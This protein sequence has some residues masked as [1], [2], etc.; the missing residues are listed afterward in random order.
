[1]LAFANAKINLGLFITEKR[2]DG[3]HNLDTVFYPIKINDVIEITDAAFTHCCIV[4]IDVPGNPD[5]NLCMEAYKAVSKDFNIPAQ[6]ITLLKNIPV[7][8]GLGGGSADAAFLIKLLNDK[9]K[10]G[11]T[12]TEME[13]YV[14][15][16]GADCAFFINNKPVLAKGKGDEFSQLELDLSAYYLVLVKPDIHVSTSDAYSGIKPSFPSTS[17]EELIHLPLSE[18]R[19]HVFNDFESSVF[20]IYPQIR[21]IKEA[22]YHEGAIFALMSGSGSSVFAIFENPVKLP[23][24]EK[25]NVVFYNV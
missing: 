15:P 2:T 4:G 6:Q 13:N 14:K 12:S 10:L 17:L 7:G 24:L 8:A 25:D 23:S 16:L 3:Y 19:H 11:L 18:W 21:S 5:D 1:M 9:Y 22:L 20:V